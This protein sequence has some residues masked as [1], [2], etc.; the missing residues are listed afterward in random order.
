MVIE[1]IEETK[2]PYYSKLNSNGLWPAALTL[3]ILL[4]LPLYIS[5]TTLKSK[6][7]NIN[8]K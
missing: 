1:E 2:I 6:N 4:I 7:L 5:I 8:L 3:R